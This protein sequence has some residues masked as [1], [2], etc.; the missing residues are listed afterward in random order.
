MTKTLEMILI[1]FLS[2]FC[3]FCG[4]KYSQ[5]FKEHAGWLFENGG[6][7]VELPDLSNTQNPE[8]DMPVDDNGKA[9][10]QVTPPAEDQNIVPMVEDGSISPTT[11][12]PQ[13][14]GE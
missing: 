13:G 8:T 7:E 3:F 5:T 4:V 10:D 9:I 14:E 11:E 1:L 6:D 12:E 2:V